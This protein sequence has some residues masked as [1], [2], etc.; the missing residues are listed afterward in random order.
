MFFYV[1]FEGSSCLADVFS[2]CGKGVFTRV[3]DLLN[4]S[5]D[6]KSVLMLSG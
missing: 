5:L 6:V 1:D 2:S 3:S 4:V